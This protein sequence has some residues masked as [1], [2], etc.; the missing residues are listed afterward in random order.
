MFQ[1]AKLHIISLNGN[2][3]NY[4]KKSDDAGKTNQPAAWIVATVL[5]V[6]LLSSTDIRFINNT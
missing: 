5:D 6:S 2:E 4:D 3:F 1:T